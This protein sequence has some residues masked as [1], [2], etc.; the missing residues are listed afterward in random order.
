MACAS[1]YGKTQFGVVGVAAVLA[2]VRDATLEQRA[3]ESPS[4]EGSECDFLPGQVQGKHWLGFASGTFAERVVQLVDQIHLGFYFYIPVELKLDEASVLVPESTCEEPLALGS[5][6]SEN[7]AGDV[8]LGSC[9][10][11]KVQNV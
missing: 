1:D 3:F 4:G 9:F 7:I 11:Q 2:S 6:Y 5:H 8:S 10:L